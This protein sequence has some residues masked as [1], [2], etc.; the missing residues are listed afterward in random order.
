MPPWCWTPSTPRNWAAS[1]TPTSRTP[2]SICPASPSTAPPAARAE[3]DVRGFGPQY[4]IVTLNNRILAT[5]DD[6]RDLAFDVLPS[7]VISGADVLKSSEASALEGSIGGTVNLRTASP[8]DNPGF[9]G[10]VHAEGDYNEMTD[11]RATSFPPSCRTPTMPD[12]LGFLLGGVIQTTRT[13][14]IRSM[15]TTRTSTADYPGRTLVVPA[16]AASPSGRS[17]TRRSAKHCPAVGVASQR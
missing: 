12:T 13:A 16:R 17:S 3:G 10:G 8:F 5:D 4:N 14:P 1:R 7:E 15:P 9:H 11:S 6:S 2:W